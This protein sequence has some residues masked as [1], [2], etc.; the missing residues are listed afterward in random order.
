MAKIKMTAARAKTL[1][2]PGLYSDHGGERRLY[3]QVRLQEGDGYSRSWIYRYVSP[4]RKVPRWAGLGSLSEVSLSEA[5]DAAIDARRLIRAGIDPLDERTRQ[6]AAAAVA[7]ARTKTFG[8]VAKLYIDGKRA[9]WSNQKHAAQWTHSLTVE[10][11]SIANLPIAAIDTGIV[12][13]VLA[14]LWS[15]KQN[16]AQRIRKRIQAVL[17]FA[18]AA[19]WRTG[20]NPARWSN[21]LEFIPALSVMR[22]AEAHLWALPFAD[23][24]KFMSELRARD[25]LTARGTEFAVLTGARSNEVLA[26]KW[27]EFDL[28]AR[29][30]TVPLARM[31]K[32]KARSEP[33][34]IPLSDRA[35]AILQALP[36]D[37]DYIF[38]TGSRQGHLSGQ[39]VLDLC[40]QMLGAQATLHGFRSAIKDWCD[41]RG[42]DDHVSECILA[43]RVK[44]KTKRAYQRSDRFT[45][46]VPV[47]QM[48]AAFC[49]GVPKDGAKI[50]PIKAR[51]AS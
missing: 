42:I 4:T 1:C 20:D 23:V 37:G 36:R 27:P 35:M 10:C 51:Q 19:E 7:A 2:E 40:K 41:S 8:E 43:H 22:K 5:R 26:A 45:D 24:P 47:M 39:T 28:G 16:T 50:L 46:R 14:P 13:S 38:A 49:G 17:D 18:G 15:K 3:L 6:T 33:H 32:D 21:H 31:Q 34:R 44:S 12:V 11:K 9:S 30:W 25:T 48:W 29:C